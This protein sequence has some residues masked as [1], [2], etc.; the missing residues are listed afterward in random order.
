MCFIL[1]SDIVPLISLEKFLPGH[2]LFIARFAQ[3]RLA[4]MKQILSLAYRPRLLHIICY[5][6]LS[7]T[8]TSNSGK[9]VLL[10]LFQCKDQI[11]WTNRLTGQ[12]RNMGHKR[13]TGMT[14]DA[15]ISVE[16]S[17]T[18]LLKCR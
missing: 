10:T 18:L 3:N 14:T 17:L 1:I 5:T 16:M 4:C 13:G 15:K 7:A 8:G 2:F 6:L 12:H 11:Y 9:F